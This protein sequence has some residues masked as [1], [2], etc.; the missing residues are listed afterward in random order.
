MER[1]TPSGL[2]GGG[3]IVARNCRAYRLLLP[4]L[5]FE[6]QSRQYTGRSPLGLKGTS[7]SF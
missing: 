6:K 1:K 4:P 7:H 3:G 2:A 5:R